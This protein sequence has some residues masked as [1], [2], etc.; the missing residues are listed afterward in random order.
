MI[1]IVTRE[2]TRES[3]TT[4]V[5]RRKAVT[6]PEKE[7]EPEKKTLDKGK[8][9]KDEVKPPGKMGF[10]ADEEEKEKEE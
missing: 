10:K 9:K 2:E 1:Q 4:V 6:E 8:E 7:K 5:N 3:T